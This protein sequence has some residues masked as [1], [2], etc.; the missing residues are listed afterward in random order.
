MLLVCPSCGR[1]DLP[2]PPRAYV[3]P[4]V[5]NLRAVPAA[6]GVALSWAVPDG[7]SQQKMGLSAIVVFQADRSACSDC[8]LSYEPVA[9][10]PVKALAADDQGNLRGACTLA[11]DGQGPFVFY[12]V[13]RSESGVNGPPSDTVTVVLPVEV[14]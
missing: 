12:V 1:K 7:F 3:P 13:A 6:E 9:T 4:V 10:V 8:P 11:V 5:Q 2:R 14:R